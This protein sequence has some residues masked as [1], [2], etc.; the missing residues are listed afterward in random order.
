M[1]VALADDHLVVREGV[2]LLL[3]DVADLEIVG[4]ASDGNEL[5][6]LLAHVQVD[7]VI[8]DLRMPGSDG[9]DALSRIRTASPDT[10]TVVLS[11]YDDPTYIRRAIEL[12]ASAYLLKNA[13]REELVKAIEEAAAGRAYIQRDL[14]PA[15]LD[16]AIERPE[17]RVTKP[18][19]EYQLSVLRLVADG[20]ETSVIATELETTESVIKND[21]KGIFR[22]LNAKTRS[23]AVAEAFRRGLLS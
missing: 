9:F 11:M 10:K 4:E 7:V 1:R 8:L 3:E 16:E 19:T 5:L 18:L 13:Q 6:D 15:I 17:H 21:L 20:I 22:E 2:R 12:G 23:Q 14:L